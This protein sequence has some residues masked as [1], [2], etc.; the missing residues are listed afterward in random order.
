[1]V[2]VIPLNALSLLLI[3]DLGRIKIMKV[4][5]DQV[6]P[7]NVKYILNYF[8]SYYFISR[9]IQWILGSSHR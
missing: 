8:K 3:V 4:K 1:M 2:T 7:F 9:Q 5:Y 6:I